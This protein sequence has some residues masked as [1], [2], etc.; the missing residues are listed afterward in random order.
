MLLVGY[1]LSISWF[2]RQGAIQSHLFDIHENLPH[3]L[4]LLLILQRFSLGRWGYAGNADNSGLAVE[5][6]QGDNPPLIATFATPDKG[7]FYFQPQHD[8]IH[9][10][11]TLVGRG[12]WVIGGS[13]E[14]DDVE[15]VKDSEWN[16]A[17]HPYVLKLSWPE[18][19]R[20]SEVEILEKIAKIHQ[21]ESGSDF[22]NLL[23]GHIPVVEAHLD[24]IFPGSNTGTIR[25]ILVEKYDG[26]G[27]RQMRC[28]VFERL[29]PLSTLPEPLMVQGYIEAFLCHRALWLKGVYHCDVSAGNLMW[30]PRCKAGVLNDFDLSKFDLEAPPGRDNTGTLPF[31]AL[32]LLTTEGLQ[33]KI[34]RLYRHDAEAFAWSFAYICLNHTLK[35]DKIVVNAKHLLAAWFADINSIRSS[36]DEITGQYWDKME[37]PAYPHTKYLAASLV[38]YYLNRFDDQKRAWR[39]PTRSTI[40]ATS[41][42]TYEERTDSKHFVANVLAIRNWLESEKQRLIQSF[43]GTSTRISECYAAKW[44]ALKDVSTL[45]VPDLDLDDE[46]AYELT[47]N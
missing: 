34:K 8:V 10:G 27:A 9:A 7:P 37:A 35:G 4:L 29:V 42:M 31:M 3:F 38:G 11:T 2:D 30:H 28:I 14:K 1:D 46:L 21:Q 25:Y 24:P 13:K 16:E 47:T 41:A 45:L 23:N 39:L 6:P 33:G 17:H 12:P 32:D 36:K 26:S 15:V 40:S 22:G 43:S 20:K 44:T 18:A 19:S 5:T